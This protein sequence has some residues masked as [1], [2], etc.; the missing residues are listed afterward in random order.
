MGSGISAIEYKK[1]SWRT[2][3]DLP[4]AYKDFCKCTVTHYES[5]LVGDQ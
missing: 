5:C 1:S 4:M 2:T 3:S